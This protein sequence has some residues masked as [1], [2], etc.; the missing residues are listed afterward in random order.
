MR[1]IVRSAFFLFLGFGLLLIVAEQVWKRKN[2]E[3]FD[4]LDV[5]IWTG[6]DY[7]SGSLRGK[8]KEKAR[9]LIENLAENGNVIL[10]GVPRIFDGLL[11]IWDN[12]EERFYRV[13]KGKNGKWYVHLPGSYQ[14]RSTE[15]FFEAKEKEVREVVK[16]L[17]EMFR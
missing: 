16:K 9:K 3:K 12:W 6:G 11:E 7:I 1:K 5:K 4:Y 15:R 14:G 13:C 2:R 17:E 8:E 10:F